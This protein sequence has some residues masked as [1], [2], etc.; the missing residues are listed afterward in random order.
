MPPLAARDAGE[1][2]APAAEPPAPA[3]TAEPPAPAP[4]AEPPAL[5]QQAPKWTYS[6]TCSRHTW[7]H[8]PTEQ[9]AAPRLLVSSIAQPRKTQ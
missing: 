3:P 8:S 2:P 6:V 4:A 9:D 5:A 7:L 1:P